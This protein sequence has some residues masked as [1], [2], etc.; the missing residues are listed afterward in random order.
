MSA[1]RIEAA[2][3]SPDIREFIGLLH[4]YGV[5]C[6]VVGGEAVIHH[7]HARLT[8]DMDFFYDSSPENAAALFQVLLDFWGGRIPGVERVEEL[9]EE[10]LI[11]QFGRPPHRIDLLNRF[12]GVDFRAA[13]ETR[14]TVAVESAQGEVP[15]HFLGL[16]QL[17]E[18]KLAAGRPKDLEDLAFLRKSTR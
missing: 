5:R 7:G 6:V 12:D 3:F 16:E 11:L 18:N 9:S 15:L 2:Y 1:D 14:H 17:I 10:G 13:W 4:R 8:G